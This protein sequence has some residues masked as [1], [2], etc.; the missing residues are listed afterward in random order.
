[1]RKSAPEGFSLLDIKRFFATRR[2]QADGFQL[3][4][5]KREQAGFLA[6]VLLSESGYKHFL[7]LDLVILPKHGA[8]EC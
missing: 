8:G 4:L 5:E 7:E 2:F 1:M 6:I 3:P